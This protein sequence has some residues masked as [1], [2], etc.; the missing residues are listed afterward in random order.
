MYDSSDESRFVVKNP[1]VEAK[2]ELASLRNH[3]EVYALRMEPMRE[4]TD[5]RVVHLFQ[6]GTHM[7]PDLGR[8]YV[9][10][11]RDLTREEK[12]LI[13]E[14]DKKVDTLARF[15]GDEINRGAE[16]TKLQKQLREQQSYPCVVLTVGYEELQSFLVNAFTHGDLLPGQIEGGYTELTPLGDWYSEWCEG[17]SCEGGITDRYGSIQ[18]G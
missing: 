18:L 7:D 5:R 2:Q 13:K 8:W 15:I 14:R 9:P 3:I 16:P 10:A 11:K 6:A 1:E 4:A 17:L 12:A